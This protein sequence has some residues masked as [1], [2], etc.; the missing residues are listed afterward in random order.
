MTDEYLNY[1]SGQYIEQ[2]I[3]FRFNYDFHEF[4]DLQLKID[5]Y[6]V[7]KTYRLQ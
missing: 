7:D 4:V 2:D 1:L 6:I 3:K 5:R